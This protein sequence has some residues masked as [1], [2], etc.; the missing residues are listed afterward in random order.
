MDTLFKLC[1]LIFI[2]DS[3]SSA[4]G[5]FTK[6]KMNIT[7]ADCSN[8]NLSR[9]PMYLPPNITVLQF[10][11]NNLGNL[12]NQTFA[13]VSCPKCRLEILNIEHN[14]IRYISK[15]AFTNLS[16]LITLIL[17]MNLVVKSSL[18]AA[19]R[20][21]NQPNLQFLS[22]NNMSLLNI[23][24]EF[25]HNLSGS[26][27]SKLSMRVNDLRKFQMSVLRPLRKLRHLDISRNFMYHITPC[28][29]VGLKILDL[30]FNRLSLIHGNNCS[31]P[32][33]KRL[34]LVHNDI[35]Y[36]NKWF[37]VCFLNAEHIDL[38]LNPIIKIY[39]HAFSLLP[40]LKQLTLEK[41]CGLSYIGKRAFS[42]NNIKNISL[43]NNNIQFDSISYFSDMFSGCNNLEYLDL[44]GNIMIKT[45]EEYLISL[46]EPVKNV[47]THLHLSDNILRT[48]PKALTLFSNLTHLYLASNELA[49]LN[50]E[51]LL[52]T[53]I[54]INLYDND[55]TSINE[56]SLPENLEDFVIDLGYNP[57]A[58]TCELLWFLEIFTNG[59]FSKTFVKY[60]EKYVCASPSNL[61]GQNLTDFAK[62]IGWQSC[63]LATTTSLIIMSASSFS[64]ILVIVGSALYYYRWHFRYFLYMLRRHRLGQRPYAKAVFKY[65]AFLCYSKHDLKWVVEEAIPKLEDEQNI[66]LCIHQRDFKLGNFEV[67]NIVGCVNASKRFLIILSDKMA[68]SKW[69]QFKLSVIQTQTGRSENVNSVIVIKLGAIDQRNMTDSLFHLLRTCECIDYSEEPAAKA[70]FWNQVVRSLKPD[71][72]AAAPEPDSGV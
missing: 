38:S 11:N 12:S 7:F 71:A 58:C 21:L 30:D 39:S 50:R 49:S 32:T 59:R 17:D 14:H 8:R 62:T 34:S 72:G 2:I 33:I 52:P 42:N 70:L 27:I 35:M 26:R 63:L 47:V 19:F 13:V 69:C 41:V 5:I 20:S 53:L 55:I 28:P 60:N 25:F 57:F 10:N 37:F 65:D 31:M 6:C 68:Q 54:F 24:E 3:I 40:N 4:E 46:L 51:D 45:P 43:K 9:I 23:S 22:L 18:T 61:R 64:V 36:I 16:Y 48:F 15:D 1:I 56:D 67:D 66:K 29:D 44:A